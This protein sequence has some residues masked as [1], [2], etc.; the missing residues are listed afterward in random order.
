LNLCKLKKGKKRS[1]LAVSEIIGAVILLGATIAIGL[2]AWAWA[3]SAAVNSESSYG[4]AVGSNINYLKENFVV[5]N[6]NFNPSISSKSFTEWI[7]NSGNVTIYIT[8]VWASNSTWTSTP[9]S[10]LNSTSTPKFN[11][12]CLVIHAQTLSSVTVNASASFVSGDFYKFSAL[13][14]Y[15]NTNTY[16]QAR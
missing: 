9:I 4:N 12:N 6:V 15:G 7:Y 5:V 1:K 16:Q 10:T 3:R 14:V 8:R 2:A 13:G 11:C